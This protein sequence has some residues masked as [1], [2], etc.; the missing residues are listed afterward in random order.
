MIDREVKK[1]I[2][3]G[4]IDFEIEAF[5]VF[6]IEAKHLLRKL[7]TYDYKTRISAEEAL[8]SEWF[9]KDDNFRQSIF[10][11]SFSDVL[12]KRVKKFNA[13]EKLQQATLAFIVHY[14]DSNDEIVKLKKIFLQINK[15]KDGKILPKELNEGLLQ[16]KGQLITE[17]ELMHIFKNIDQDK[18]GYIEKSFYEQV[19]II[20]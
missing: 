7:L 10:E 2:I 9:N 16:I 11:N 18:N 12:I 20:L 8:K 4:R 5:D 15:N 19:W 6:S 3:R 1:D 17:N 14:L 13:K